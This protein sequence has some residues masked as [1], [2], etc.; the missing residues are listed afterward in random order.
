MGYYPPQ[1]IN[2]IFLCSPMKLRLIAV[3]S[4]L[5]ATGLL[6]AEKKAAPA[7]P[8]TWKAAAGSVVVTP[9]KNLWMA[10]YANRKKP[11]EGKAQELFAKSLALQDEQG[12][13]L[14]FVTLDLIGVPQPVRHRI[15]AR[16]QK[17][18]GLGP[19]F[20]VL[21]ASHTHSGPSLR[22]AI[23]T[24]KELQDPRIRDTFEYTQGLE[25]KIFQLVRDT[26]ARLEPAR[27]T[28]NRARSGFAMNRRLPTPKGYQNSP[29]P[30]GPVDH[31]VPVLRVEAAGGELRAMMF[32]YSCHNTCLGFY[33]Y[34]GDYA[35]FAQEY[36]QANRKNFTALF[37][38]GCA[39]DQNPYPRGNGVV[40]GLTDLDLAKQHGRTLATA[41]E[42]ANITPQ[43]DVR[44]PLRAAYEEVMLDYVKEKARPQHAYPVQ[45][46]AFG[47]DLTL[48]TLG[49]EVVVDYSLRL[50]RE[51]AGAAAVWIA[52]YSNDYVGYIPSV[53][54]LKEGGYE[55]QQGWTDTVEE[56]IVGKV[57]ELHRRVKSQAMTSGR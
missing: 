29:N 31:E 46:I 22:G 16:V 30:D 17:E 15:A 10:G 43:R 8:L 6:A 38:M 50:K 33:N 9:T 18:L 12:Q 57:H 45:V 53:R 19:Q 27:L 5:S 2:E 1:S 23:P 56:R 26:L 49:S 28:W 25:E 36:L 11:A 3:V 32:G 42:M 44:G 51:L 47:N 21:N 39:G 34:C 24:E 37:L 52:G 54:V 35:G 55:A 41:A 40:P 13:K 7:L 48:V 20:L 14:V 4:L